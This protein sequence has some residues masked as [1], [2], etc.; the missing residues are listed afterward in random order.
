MRDRVTTIMIVDDVPLNI[1]VL[2]KQLMQAGYERFVT[3]TDAT[4]AI[5]TMRIEQPDILLLDLMMPEVSGLEILEKVRSDEKLSSIP[6]I[7]LT[8]CDQTEVKREALE[9]GA[10]DFLTKPFE[11][12]DLVPRIRNALELRFSLEELQQAKDVAETANRAK[13]EFLANMSHEIRTPMN[14]IIGMTNLVLDTQLNAEQ[15]DCL[16]T[17]KSCSNHLLAL[18]NDILDLSKIEAGR[19]DLEAIDFRPRTTV[20]D[21]IALFQLKATEKGIDLSYD[22]SPDVPDSLIGDPFRLQQI[23]MN[24]LSNAVKFTELGEISV[25]VE[26]R[27]L[28][29]DCT[30]LHFSV[31]DT[32][33]GIEPEQQQAI[34]DAFAQA[35]GSTSRKYGGT[36]LGL[37]ISSRLVQMMGGQ[38]W[39]ESEPGKGSLFH[40]TARFGLG[41]SSHSN[42][43]VRRDKQK[44]KI[45]HKTGRSLQILIAED[46]EFNRKVLAWQLKKWGHRV[47]TANDGREALKALERHSFDLILMD[48]QMPH[49][50]GLETTTKIRER[51]KLTGE[52]IPI[53]A[54]TAHALKEYKEKCLAAGMD[55]YISKPIDPDELRSIIDSL[56]GDENITVDKSSIVEAE[57]VD[58]EAVIKR[59]GGDRQALEE[60]VEIWLRDS[61]RQLR[62]IGEAVDA[63]DS[64]RLSAVAHALKGQISFFTSGP[65]LAAVK[66]LETMGQN[67]DLSSAESAYDELQE[68]YERLAR[69]ISS[70]LCADATGS[71]KDG[72]SVTTDE[73]CV[74][75]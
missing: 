66:R 14:G 43:R 62:E 65:P 9:L 53:V 24:L 39:V 70:I 75:V 19:L 52:H 26:N 23:L 44:P 10:F 17:V 7:V 50:D 42:G 35:D 28:E 60:L 67:N 45:P 22:F 46:E 72:S 27:M 68:T 59:V 55:G 15:R 64:Q 47:T 32:G 63:E 38:L 56:T 1:Y 6:V 69:E 20:E 31:R 71:V 51:E 58:T 18:I 29:T 33:I 73:Q 36:G 25:F 8:A 2:Q 40:F 41:P 13:S 49:M 21:V 4:R 48:V 74:V 5:E 54:T 61:P 12:S 37:A 11:L 30:E 34:F 16:E 57:F 3:L